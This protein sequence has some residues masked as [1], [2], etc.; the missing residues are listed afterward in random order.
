MNW[1]KSLETGV[2]KIDAQHKELFVQADKLLDRTQAARVPETL[3]FLKT[4]VANHFAAEEALQ[5]VTAY[6]KADFH[7]KLHVDFTA[8]FKKLYEE[9]KAS[10][11]KLMVVL[12]INKLVIDW[13]KD[14]IMIHDKEFANYYLKKMGK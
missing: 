5:K 14:H 6:P 7:R 3:E 12:N 2:P 13:L 10:G 4:Y 9:Y 1:N 11:E 8:T